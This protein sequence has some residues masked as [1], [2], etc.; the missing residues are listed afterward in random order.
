MREGIYDILKAKFLVSQD[1]I[2]NWGMIVMLVFLSLLMIANIHFFESKLTRIVVLQAEIKELSSEFADVRS[3]LMQLKMESSV[4]KKM[5]PLGIVSSQVPPV[6][7][8]VRE[9][10]VKE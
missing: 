10:E 9:K 5:E 4:A 3:R 2:S 8:I 6:K 1:S 7:L